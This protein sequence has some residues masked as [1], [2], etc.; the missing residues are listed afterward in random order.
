MKHTVTIEIESDLDPISLDFLSDKV[1]Y[2]ASEILW[3]EYYPT[4]WAV[5]LNGVETY[6]FYGDE[7]N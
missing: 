5:S 1:A 6:S 4:A 2:L 3:N 7:D